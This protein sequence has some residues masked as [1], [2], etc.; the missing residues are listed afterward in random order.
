MSIGTSTLSTGEGEGIGDDKKW[1]ED[2]HLLS[3]PMAYQYWQNADTPV[4][5]QAKEILL[6]LENVDGV[7]KVNLSQPVTCGGEEMVRSLEWLSKHPREWKS[8]E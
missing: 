4:M 5:H 3:T 2:E 7:N 6:L 8:E 1:R